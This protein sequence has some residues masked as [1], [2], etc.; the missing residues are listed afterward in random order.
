MIRIVRPEAALPV[1][2]LRGA[3]Q[4]QKDCNTF[5]LHPLQYRDGRLKFKANGRLYGHKTVKDHLLAAQHRKCCYCERKI[6]PSNFGDVEHFRPKAGI[7]QKGSPALIKPGYYWLAYDWNNLLVSCSVCN[8]AWKQTYFPLLNERR[9]AR[10][11]GD[12]IADEHP[13]LV[14]PASEDPRDHIRYDSDSPYALTRR[15]QATI[16]R[17]GLRRGDL[18]EARK[19]LLTTLT[20]LRET[21]TCLKPFDSIRTAAEMHLQSLAAPSSEFS[22]MV[23]DFLASPFVPSKSQELN[24]KAR[25]Q[26]PEMGRA[27]E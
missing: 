7:R 4:T 16:D 2:A 24:T 12:Q 6:L 14:D 25:A 27:H 21:A 8:T 23:I 11:H 1:L 9:R 18:R 19:D 13:M 10:W 3:A 17:L 15:G 20:L 26:Q 5:N 22:S